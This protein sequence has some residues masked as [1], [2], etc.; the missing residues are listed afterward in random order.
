[1]GY[2]SVVRGWGVGLCGGSY[3]APLWIVLSRNTI[4]FSKQKRYRKTEPGLLEEP[5]A[6][7][8]RIKA[9]GKVQWVPSKVVPCAPVRTACS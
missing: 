8:W 3:G 5:E 9:F 7:T 6:G 4:A 2:F 1:M